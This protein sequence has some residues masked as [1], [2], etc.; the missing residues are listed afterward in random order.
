MA[1]WLIFCAGLCSGKAIWSVRLDTK[2]GDRI[3]ALKFRIHYKDDSS[4]NVLTLYL[5]VKYPTVFTSLQG[6]L[7]GN[8]LA[9]KLVVQLIVDPSFGVCDHMGHQWI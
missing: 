3:P 2:E 5:C 6:G 7:E 8:L 4:F 1:K 9:G